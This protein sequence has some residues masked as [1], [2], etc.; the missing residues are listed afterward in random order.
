MRTGIR[1]PG[2]DGP[3]V[4][5]RRL[6]AVV[7]GLVLVVGGVTASPAWAAAAPTA[8]VIEVVTVPAVPGARF[9]VDGVTH[10]ADQQGSV[11]V[12]V[13]KGSKGHEV[14]LVAKD[15]HEPTRDLQFVRWWNPGDHDQDFRTKVTGIAVRHNVR[16]KA[17]FRASYLVSYAF[18]DQAQA[19]V[20]RSRV[21][22]VEFYGDNG[23]TVSGNGSGKIRM[24][25]TRP[26]V[27]GNTVVAK[28]VRYSV[29]RVDVDGSN[30]VQ[31]NRQ[32]FSPTATTSLVV[33]L[34]LRTAHFSTRDFLLGSPVGSAVHLTYPD[35]RQVVVPLDADGKATVE[36]LARGQYSVRVEAAGYSF[37]RPIVLSRNQYVDLP[38]LTFLD[39]SILGGLGV[40]VLGGLLLLRIRARRHRLAAAKR[41]LCG[42]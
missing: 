12:Q 15:I 28:P 34:L 1:G 41:Q 18:V 3:L 17:A 31:V 32:V 7:G 39:L 6:L 23:H 9:V 16:I 29:Q 25:G 33:P 20:K 36:N 38:V 27:N 10:R 14:S 2:A 19:E 8:A 22:R 21:S 13:P 26:T 4:R 5:V 11:R 24:V 40:G 37:D 30:V 42:V 35:K